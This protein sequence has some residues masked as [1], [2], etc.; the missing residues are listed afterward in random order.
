MKLAI[1]T[2]P[3]L[4]VC[5][6][7]EI[8][9]TSDA[10]YS[11]VS[12]AIAG[13]S[14]GDTVK[15]PIN[16]S[17]T[18]TNTLVIGKSITT[19]GN[20]STI[21]GS[22]TGDG[23][24]CITG[25]SSTNLTRITGFQFDLVDSNG[26]GVVV[27]DVTL[28]SLRIDHNAFVKGN[29]PIDVGGS[30]GVIDHNSFSN[31]VSGIYYTA[32]T[33]AQADASWVSMA[34]GT[35]DALFIEDNLFAIDTNYPNAGHNTCIDTYNGGKLVVRY[36]SFIAT[37]VLG[38]FTIFSP[39]LTHGNAVG[40]WEGDSG[41]RRGQSVVE[42]YN[43]H[44]DAKRLDHF[45][46]FRGSANLV[47]SNHARSATSTPGMYCY[48][49]EAYNFSPVRTNWP[50]EDQ[51][52]NTFLWD[53]TMLLNSTTNAN[54]F[55]VATT[56]TNFIQLNRDYFLHAPQATG[57]SEYFTGTNGAAG[58]FPTDGATYPT[59]GTMAFT[60]TGTN[61]YYGYQP[62][63]YPHPL[64]SGT[65]QTNTVNAIFNGGFYINNGRIGN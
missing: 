44:A 36:N 64:T 47:Y 49:E 33:R 53:N 27:R 34:A 41:A 61:A 62:Y 28:G 50:A 59:L 30:K 5:A 35:G 7:G 43:N 45:F 29:I 65:A 38:T 55:S 58:T 11:A 42:I 51:V 6:Q 1:W 13:A 22:L 32:G 17:A 19:D 60:A 12:N 21:S 31:G 16:L 10:S 57:G 4:L 63:T 54:Y 23:L 2:L 9:L 20:G 40:Y 52:H 8:I 24:L 26:C 18:W 56:S 3:F 39:G 37:N 25:F 14:A 46:V 15:L 48:E